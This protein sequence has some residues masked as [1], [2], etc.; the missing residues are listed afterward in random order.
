MQLIK[1]LPQHAAHHITIID[2]QATALRHGKARALAASLPG[3]SLSRRT[4]AREGKPI[5]GP[6]YTRRPN[7]EL[8]K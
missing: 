7:N 3:G 2:N 4:F 8:L 6:R 5:L 1:Q